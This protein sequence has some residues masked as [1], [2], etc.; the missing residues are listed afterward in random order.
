MDEIERV[1]AEIVRKSVREAVSELQGEL[2]AAVR[3][4]RVSPASYGQ[5]YITVK[6]AARIMG[7]H[8]STVR[9]LVAAGKLSRYS[10]EGQLRIKVADLHA[11]LAR[12]PQPGPP[13]DLDRRALEILSG[14]SATGER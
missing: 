7:A 8:P 14:G 13:I 4:A 3:E 9:K 2:V 6:E 1:I 10:V 5:E 12:E 11:Y